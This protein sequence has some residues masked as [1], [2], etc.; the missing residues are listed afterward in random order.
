MIEN[1][2]INLVRM[3]LFINIPRLIIQLFLSVLIAIRSKFSF[4]IIFS[5]I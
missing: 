3:K 5:L 1:S 4:L 2:D